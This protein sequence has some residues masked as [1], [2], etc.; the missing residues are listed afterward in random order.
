MGIALQHTKEALK[1]MRRL[2]GGPLVT[3]YMSQSNYP[4]ITQIVIISIS[5]CNFSVIDN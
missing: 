3:N 4:N 5:F 2:F 1:S